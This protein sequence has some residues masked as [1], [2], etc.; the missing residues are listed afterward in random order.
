MKINIVNRFAAFYKNMSI[1]YR[2]LLLFFVQIII[3]LLFIGYMSYTK[4]SEVIQN[5]SIAYSQDLL[6]MIEVRLNDLSGNVDSLSRDLLFDRRVYDVLSFNGGEE[7]RINYYNN[8]IDVYNILRKT[9]LSR[10]EIQSV[11]F[12][13]L[14]GDMYSFDS[15]SG[16]ANIKQMLPYKDIL[17]LAREVGGKLFWYIDR[18]GSSV[19]NIYV[20]KMVNNWDNFK[21]IGFLA[22]LIKKEYLESIYQDLSSDILNNVSIITYKNEEILSKNKDY[23]YLL[24]EFY[25]RKLQG[26]R[27]YYIDD[28]NKMLVSYVSIDKLQWTVVS[29]ISLKNLYREIDA[30]RTWNILMGIISLLILSI[31]SIATSFDIIEPLNKLVAGMKKVE[32]GEG[33]EEINLSR[34]DELGYLS[35][36]FNKMSRRIDFLVNNMYRE[37]ITRKEAELKALQAQINPHFLFNTLDSINWMAQ[38]NGVPQISETVTALAQLMDASIGRDDKLI[39]LKEEL[40]YINSYIAII[41]NRYENKLEVTKHVDE[42]LLDV[43]IP[44]LLIQPLVENAVYHGIEKITR[45]GRIEIKVYGLEGDVIIEVTDNGVGMKEDEIKALDERL[46][47][48]DSPLSRGSGGKRNSIGLENVNRRIKLFYGEE[49]GLVLESKYG[50]YTKVKVRIP[51][52]MN[53]GESADVQG[54]DC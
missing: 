6:N 47:S 13:S 5:K 42:A 10:Q 43:N 37:Q 3:P 15:N 51:G 52:K 34:N 41:K 19:E 21:E 29:H 49:Y 16:H 46:A 1:R 44:R 28:K 7:E 24:K 54:V 38:L 36:S 35:R 40:D 12:A 31:L 2:L 14:E 50:E 45:N 20:A 33:H 30:L 4:S 25:S 17:N 48:D 23:S 53:K 9:A 22:V 18:N 32:K 27:G 11:C 26:G 8:V 39:S